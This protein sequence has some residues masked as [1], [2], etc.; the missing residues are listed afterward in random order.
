MPPGIKG[1]DPAA[2]GGK[3]PPPPGGW[4]G[5]PADEG[6]SLSLYDSAEGCMCSSTIPLTLFFETDQFFYNGNYLTCMH[7]SK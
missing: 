6:Q 2:I 7:E 3:T 5:A 4:V 1:P